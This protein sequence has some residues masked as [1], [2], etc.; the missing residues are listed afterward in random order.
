MSK[1]I[2]INHTEPNT[3]ITLFRTYVRKSSI[4]AV[5]KTKASNVDENWMVSIYCVNN[6]MLSESFENEVDCDDRLSEIICSL[7]HDE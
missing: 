5:N 2:L 7:E 3:N 6:M 1:F 4:T